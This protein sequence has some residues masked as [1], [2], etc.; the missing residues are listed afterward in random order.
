MKIL[1]IGSRIKHAEFGFGVV[2]NVTSKHYWVTFIEKG[3]ETIDI[4]CE[5]EVIEA[6]EDEV[7]SVSFYDVER[8]LKSLLQKWSDVSQIVPIADKW[9]GGKLIMEPGTPTQNKEVPIDTFFHKIIMVRDRIRVMEQKINASN[10]D[11]A[12]KIDLQQYI[13]RIYG[14][15]TTFNVLFKSTNDYFVGEKSK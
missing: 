15:L 7:D 1:G 5:F 12:E 8:T 3:L 4:D 6:L 14:S 11:E 2:T 13:T 10:L 9:K